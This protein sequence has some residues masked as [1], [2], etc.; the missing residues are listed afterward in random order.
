[1]KAIAIVPHTK[2]IFLTDVE[3]PAIRSADDVKIKIWH[4]GIC[5]TDREETAGG[6]ADAPAGKKNL[7][8]GHE[9]FGQVVEVGKNVTTVKPGDFAVCTVRRGCGSCKACLNNRSDMCYTGNY[10]ERGIKGADGYQAEYVVDSEQYVVKLPED[11]ADI[12]VLTEPMSV[13]AKAIDEAMMIQAARLKD[14][15]N[16]S[17]WLH[18]K[19]ALVA[20]IGPI[21][22]M[23]AFALRLKGAEVI[24]L[25]IVEEQSIR[26]QL[27]EAIG[28]RYLNGN[29]IQVTDIDDKIGQIDFA[30]E[31]TGIATLQFQLIDTLGINAI[32]VATGIPSGE[33]SLT[34]RGGA[35]MQQLVL[36]NQVV[37]G[38]VNA[39][40]QHYRQA[41]E[42]LAQSKK[43][44]PDLIKKV[45]T[46]R[47]PFK[48]FIQAFEQH[49]ADEIKAIIDWT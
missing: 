32:Y 17:D 10:T 2:Q 22:L 46:H 43:R 7:I 4:V 40:I 16:P 39:G 31:A 30:F 49:P 38:S 11:I 9:M 47:F 14:F 48:D 45:I 3:E 12:G 20:G 28:G 37:L 26:A 34:L 18:G 19:R 13:A 24:G 5:G 6:R 8:I 36:M 15:D 21:G 41:V 42:Y 23:A 35:L 33:R 25:D 1:M 27:L 29:I 44:W